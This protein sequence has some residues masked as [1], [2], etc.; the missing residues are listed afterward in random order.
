MRLASTKHERQARERATK[1]AKDCVTRLQARLCKV[2]RL[3]EKGDNDSWEDASCE[4]ASLNLLVDRASDC[5]SKEVY[6]RIAEEF[7][8]R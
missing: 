8:N 5:V 1:D 2:K 7:G 4:L 3:I 6:R